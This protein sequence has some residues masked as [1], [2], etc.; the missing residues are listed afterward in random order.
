MNRHKISSRVYLIVGILACLLM[1]IQ[2]ILYKT[3]VD[4]IDYQQEQMASAAMK[5]LNSSRYQ[6]FRG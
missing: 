1:T 3:T 4:T 5:K 6:R 2:L